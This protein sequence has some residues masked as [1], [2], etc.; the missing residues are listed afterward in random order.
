MDQSTSTSKNARPDELVLHQEPLIYHTIINSDE[1]DTVENDSDQVKMDFVE[2]PSE[3][4]KPLKLVAD[5][6][7]ILIPLALLGVAIAISRLDGQEI[8]PQTFKLWQN[9]VRLVRHPIFQFS[10]AI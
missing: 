2:I 6:A 9:A 1:S 5:A 3:G 7:A 8:E 4:F 10:G